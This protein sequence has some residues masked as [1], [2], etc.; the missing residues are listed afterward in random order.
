MN[1]RESSPDMVL[2]TVR[3]TNL[4]F[5]TDA[6]LNNRRIGNHERERERDGGEE[7]DV[8]G[9]EREERGKGLRRWKPEEGQ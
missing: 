5:G 4:I 7:E 8:L 6:T 2:D 9:V 1:K 3:H